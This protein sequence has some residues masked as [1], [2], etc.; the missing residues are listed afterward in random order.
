MSTGFYAFRKIQ[1]RIFFFTSSILQRI[2]WLRVFP[3]FSKAAY[4]IFKSLSASFVTLPFLTLILLGS[5]KDH[6]HCVGIT[7]IIPGNFPIS[8]FLIESH[9]QVYFA[10]NVT[11][12]LVWGIR[13][14]TSLEHY[15]V[16]HTGSNKKTYR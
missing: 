14:R 8:R 9:M 13:M 16:Y 12:S 11:Y 2:L 6:S 3:F 15:S 4:K 10:C 1:G 7:Q 5:Y